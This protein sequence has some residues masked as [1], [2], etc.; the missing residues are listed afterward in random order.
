M[1]KFITLLIACTLTLGFTACDFLD[2]SD[3]DSFVE[4]VSEENTSAALSQLDAVIDNFDYYS[5]ED[6]NKAIYGVA[7]LMA[8]VDMGSKVQ[9][10]LQKAFK[11]MYSVLDEN[12][13]LDDEDGIFAEVY[14]TLCAGGSCSGGSC[15]GDDDDCS[16]G[17]CYGDDDDCSGGSCYGGDDDCSGGS[18]YGGDD[19]CSGGSCYGGGNGGGGGRTTTGTGGSADDYYGN[20]TD[21]VENGNVAP[22]E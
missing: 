22:G 9:K 1:R 19:D 8:Q 16:G 14:E 10:K 17:S 13:A 7:G 6:Q 21:D 4:N 11:H 20:A 15:Y 12:D 3:V 18:C 2:D 5:E